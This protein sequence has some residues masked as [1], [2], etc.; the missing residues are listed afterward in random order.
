M[1]KWFDHTSQ[2]LFVVGSVVPGT[3]NHTRNRVLVARLVGETIASVSRLEYITPGGPGG[4]PLF[5]LF[6]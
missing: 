4:P 6:R 3:R 2:K 1:L 5:G